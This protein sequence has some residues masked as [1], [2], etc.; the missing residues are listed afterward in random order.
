[1]QLRYKSNSERWGDH[2]ATAWS[3][4]PCI[5]LALVARFP[6]AVSL[7][8]EVASLVQVWLPLSFHTALL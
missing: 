5:A 8:T 1:M 3:I 6:G 7:K 4:D 2:V